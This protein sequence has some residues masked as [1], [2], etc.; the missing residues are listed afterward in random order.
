MYIYIYIYICICM[1][2][3]IYIYIYLHIYIYIYMYIYIHIYIYMCL[4]MVASSA[5]VL[6]LPD[7]DAAQFAS[8][9]A[10]HWIAWVTVPVP[11]GL[12]M[13]SLPV[14]KETTYDPSEDRLIVPRGVGTKASRI[15]CSTLPS[16]GGRMTYIC[17]RYKSITCTSEHTHTYLYI[18]I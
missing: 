15:P 12:V 16:S 1:Y 6:F 2:V 13:V 3:Y 5:T 9:R 8:L 14:S 17:K 18:Y 4:C 7:D 10:S 11:S